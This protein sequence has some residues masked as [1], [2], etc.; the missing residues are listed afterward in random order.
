MNG[1]IKKL[2]LKDDF[3]KF[4]NMRRIFV[5]DLPKKINIF[6]AYQLPVL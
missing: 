4:L 6:V 5:V 3:T 2:I 1:F